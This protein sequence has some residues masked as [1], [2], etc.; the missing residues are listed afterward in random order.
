MKK[1]LVW[2]TYS[3]RPFGA[4]N[5]GGLLLCQQFP[6]RNQCERKHS[7]REK[8]TMVYQVYQLLS[9]PVQHVHYGLTVN[10]DAT[11]HER[12]HIYQRFH[13]FAPFNR[14]IFPSASVLLNVFIVSCVN[15]L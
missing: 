5:T 8:V 15:P 9:E 1:E 6:D 11:H 2:H 14:F 7:T 3:F 4:T 10:H 12:I 13:F